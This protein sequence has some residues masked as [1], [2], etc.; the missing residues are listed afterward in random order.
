MW[1]VPPVGILD[2]IQKHLPM[3]NKALETIGEEPLEQGYFWSSTSFDKD[4]AWL[5]DIGTGETTYMAQKT[6]GHNV[7]LVQPW[8][9]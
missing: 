7:C 6:D 2:I 9:V 4:K 5:V 1:H 3:I 8:S